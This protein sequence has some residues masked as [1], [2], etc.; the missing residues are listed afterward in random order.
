M[1]TPRI[2]EIP[3]F[4]GWP[5]E[6]GRRSDPETGRIYHLTFDPP[7]PEI[8]PRLV[9]RKDDTAEACGARLA[10]YHSETAPIVPFYEAKGILR[11][12]DGVASPDEVT[13]RIEAAL[14]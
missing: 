13:R 6:T 11:R 2:A 10:K 3:A 4:S 1:L 9:H 5:D 12:V 14:R 8:A 7:P